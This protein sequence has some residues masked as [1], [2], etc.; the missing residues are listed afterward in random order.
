MTKVKICGVKRQETLE[1]LAELKVDYVGFLFAESRRRISAEEAGKLLRSA[2][3]PPAA[4]GVFVNPTFSELEEVL[5]YAPLSVIQL[6][7]T[8]SP[9]F[10]REVADRFRLP[11]WKAIAVSAEE[12]LTEV[13]KSYQGAV[14]AF[15]FDT[16]DPKQAGGTGK[17]FSWEVIPRLREQAKE[18]ICIIAGGIN[19]SNV[20]ELLV[21]YQPQMIDISSGV[22]TDG[23]KDRE[24]IR[25][26]MQRV[27]AYDH[28]DNR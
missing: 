1:L 9:A 12:R 24:K 25:R 15:L 14:D 27:R 22:E 2:Q 21:D 11:V 5:S 20:G 28:T 4:V 3:Y 23:E 19:E 18:T 10:C 16:H 17:R 6:H 7:G 13:L 26:F 8:E